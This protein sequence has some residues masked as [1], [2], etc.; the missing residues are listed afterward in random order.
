MANNK[1]E[2]NNENF[3]IKSLSFEE[4][5]YEDPG[6]VYLY[7]YN[8]DNSTLICSDFIER[9]KMKSVVINDSDSF[10]EQIYNIIKGW[11]RNYKPKDD[12]FDSLNWDLKITLQDETSY[13]FKGYHDTPENFEA[14]ED[15]LNMLSEC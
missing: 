6:R 13:R 9:E 12:I 4:Y 1:R 11:K 2:L 14:F 3:K 8:N 7:T 5:S 15:F 10:N